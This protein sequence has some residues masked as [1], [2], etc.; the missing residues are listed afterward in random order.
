MPDVVCAIRGGPGSYQTRL[1]ALQHGADTDAGVRFLSVIDPGI[2]EPLH[3]GEQYAIRAEMAWRD[4]ALAKAITARAD[5]DDA[6]F[7]VTVRVGDLVDTISAFAGEV[8]ADTILIGTPRPAADA[9]FA[10]DGV[11][12]FAEEL[13]QKTGARVM[14]MSP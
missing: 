12:E 14:V 8:E 3:T 7:T 13:R 4:L 9:R 10:A 6:R 1:A 11:G 2:Y 5:L